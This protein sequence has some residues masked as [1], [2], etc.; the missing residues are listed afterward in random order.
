MQLPKT[1]FLFTNERKY[2]DQTEDLGIA[3][4]GLDISNAASSNTTGYDLFLSRRNRVQGHSNQAATAPNPFL[5]LATADAAASYARHSR[6]RAITPAVGHL[7]YGRDTGDHQSGLEVSSGYLNPAQSA[8]GH[9]R[10][11]IGQSG[12]RRSQTPANAQPQQYA[13]S[14]RRP[15]SAQVRSSSRSSDSSKSEANV[16]GMKVQKQ[17]DWW[18]FFK[19]GR[20]CASE[21]PSIYLRI[22]VFI[23]RWIQATE[24]DNMFTEFVMF[25]VVRPGKYS[26]NCMYVDPFTSRNVLRI[27]GLSIRTATG[28]QRPVMLERGITL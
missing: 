13:A 9:G 17:K 5:G 4:Q 20:V 28:V 2:K 16:S 6:R 18:N 14:L 10:Q 15:Q 21:S 27:A 24:G 26:S 19:P 3:L 23:A 1:I 8:I 11:E 7:E 25:V 22:Q 12:R